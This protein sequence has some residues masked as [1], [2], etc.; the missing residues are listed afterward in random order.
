[1]IYSED[2]VPDGEAEGLGQLFV[3]LMGGASVLQCPYT[4]SSTGTC[5]IPLQFTKFCSRQ[6]KGLLTRFTG[7]ASVPCPGIVAIGDALAPR[8]ALGTNVS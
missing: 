7:G 6:W 5:N 3:S 4:P 1:M 2:V 8:K